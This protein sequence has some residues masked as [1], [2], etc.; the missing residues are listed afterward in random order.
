MRSYM[1]DIECEFN[2][3]HCETFEGKTYRDAQEAAE[4]AG[5]YF[6]QNQEQAIGR[7]TS[8]YAMC[9]DC[10]R[11]LER[12]F[13][14]RF[15]HDVSHSW[16]PYPQIEGVNGRI[17]SYRDMI[18]S[19]GAEERLP[20][21]VTDLKPCFRD[22]HWH[23]TDT[24]ESACIVDQNGLKI[25]DAVSDA[26]TYTEDKQVAHLWAMA[27][28]LYNALQQLL[29]AY[30]RKE[31]PGEVIQSAADV[32]LAATVAL[33]YRLVHK[34]S[35]IVIHRENLHADDVAWQNDLFVQNRLPM[36]WEIED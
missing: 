16:F 24:S 26:G 34:D 25:G 31:D 8:K 17:V 33:P 18:N 13:G 1:Y 5:W 28:Q 12:Y 2:S 21:F 9:P 23:A 4:K 14:L 6:G 27:P 11:S 15:E 3:D 36:H 7:Y 10:K 35:S 20:F 22:A 32:L 30:E 19:K 29:R